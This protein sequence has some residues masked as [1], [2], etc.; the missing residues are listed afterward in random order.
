[1]G[2]SL[3]V[4]SNASLLL[5]FSCLKRESLSMTCIDNALTFGHF[6]SRYESC[7]ALYP[8]YFILR[9][10]P[11]LCFL[12]FIGCITLCFVLSSFLYQDSCQHT[13]SS[14]VYTLSHVVIVAAASSILCLVLFLLFFSPSL[15][16]CFVT[17]SSLQFPFVSLC[18]AVKK[19]ELLARDSYLAESLCADRNDD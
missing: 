2:S 4:S 8:L 18:F 13:F 9:Y 17:K 19:R 11:F 16:V 3:M 10:Y 1:M 14:R 6:D 7:V 5:P 15:S 12:S